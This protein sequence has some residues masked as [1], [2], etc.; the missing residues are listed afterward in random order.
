MALQSHILVL[1]FKR[2]NTNRGWRK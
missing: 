2:Y 1:N